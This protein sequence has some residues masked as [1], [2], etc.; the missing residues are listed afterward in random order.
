MPESKPARL[1]PADYLAAV[2]QFLALD[3]AGKRA[4]LPP[5]FPETRFHMQDADAEFSSPFRFMA[6]LAAECCKFASD[7]CSADS[8]QEQ[9]L[10]ELSSLLDTF[11]WCD[12]RARLWDLDSDDSRLTWDAVARL[13]RLA[14]DAC[15][16]EAV[17]PNIPCVELLDKYSY[18][19]YSRNTRKAKR[20]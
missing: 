16:L 12:R 19:D 6:Q 5:P 18:G 17:P 14:L 20:R 13:A 15:D 9:L 2:L 1:W 8:A 4:Y 10:L 7:S 3:A 11:S